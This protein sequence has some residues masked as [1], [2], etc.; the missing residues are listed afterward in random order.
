MH[1]FNWRK[2]WKKDVKPYLLNKTVQFCLDFGMGLLEPEWKSGDAPHLLGRGLMNG[3]RVVRNKLSYFQPIGRCHH[4]SF[5]S[6]AIGKLNYPELEWRIVSGRDHTIPVGYLKGEPNMVMDILLFEDKSANESL[7]FAT[8]RVDDN[9]QWRT[10]F[11]LFESNVYPS[12][13]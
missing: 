6:G 2:R 5:F 11:E 8:A 7:D 3:Q 9:Y 12:L 4:I 10:Y 1:S 13:A